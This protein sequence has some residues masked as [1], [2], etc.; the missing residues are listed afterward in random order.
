MAKFETLESV[1]EALDSQQSS[2]VLGGGSGL[3]IFGMEVGSPEWNAW[4]R[5]VNYS[6][7][8]IESSGYRGYGPGRT[9]QNW[10]P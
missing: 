10:N 5:M 2:E 7:S 6:F 3:W 9:W 8:S 1:F 4:V